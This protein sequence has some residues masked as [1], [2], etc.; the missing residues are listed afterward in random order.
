MADDHSPSEYAELPPRPAKSGPP[1]VLLVDD[2][3]DFLELMSAALA[4]EG[5]E[6]AT[7]LTA[8]A[9]V[10]RAVSDPPD[11]ILLDILLG[12]SDG[13]DVLEALRSQP[14][15]RGVPVL[16]CTALGQRDSAKLLPTLGFD[17]LLSKPLNP[18]DLARALRAHVRRRAEE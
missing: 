3:P 16:A 12:E 7:A 18:R 11:V 1:R 8:G 10:A 9:G 2:D 14:Q 4:E 13:I 15:T 5:M 17:G 6:V